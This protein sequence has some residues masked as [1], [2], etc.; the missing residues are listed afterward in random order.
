MTAVV[1]Y[2]GGFL[3]KLLALVLMLLPKSP[4]VYLDT[5]PDEVKN[6]LGIFNYFI[7]ISSM[8]AVM[9]PWL[10]A[11]GTY[12]VYSTILRWAKAVE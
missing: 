4:F 11:V 7:P 2:L 3:N 1:E 9:V 10:V 12:Y 8:L 6:V 5:V